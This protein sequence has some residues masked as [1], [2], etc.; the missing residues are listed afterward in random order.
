[1]IPYL[2]DKDGAASA[3]SENKEYGALDAICQDMMAA[4]HKKDHATLKGALEALC[5]HLKD[6]SQDKPSMNEE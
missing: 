1:M 5:E 2:E 3:P 6:E 4:F